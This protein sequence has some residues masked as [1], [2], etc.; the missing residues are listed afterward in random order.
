MKRNIEKY[1]E[2]VIF[3]KSHFVHFWGFLALKML[4]PGVRKCKFARLHIFAFF[5]L[6]PFFCFCRFSPYRR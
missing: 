5:L 1:L 2:K 3:K 6:L 4:R